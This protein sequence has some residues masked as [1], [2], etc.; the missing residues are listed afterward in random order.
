[1]NTPLA[2]RRASF[3]RSF[4]RSNC[5]GLYLTRMPSGAFSFKCDVSREMNYMAQAATLLPTK[6]NAASIVTPT[7][8]MVPINST[9][10]KDFDRGQDGIVGGPLGGDSLTQFRRVATFLEGLEEGGK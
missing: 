1:M 5:I 7:M 4:S 8:A 10:L 2:A 3:S 9:A 6:G